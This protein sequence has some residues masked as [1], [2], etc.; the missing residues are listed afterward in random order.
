MKNSDIENHWNLIE[1]DQIDENEYFEDL[2][3]RLRSSITY[4]YNKSNR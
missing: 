1:I 2:R 4:L 3:N